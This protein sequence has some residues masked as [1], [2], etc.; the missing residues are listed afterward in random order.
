M[1]VLRRL[2]AVMAI[3]VNA[4]VAVGA[5]GAV[6]G[7]AGS[8]M[9]VEVD[10]VMFRSDVTRVYCRIL[11]RPHTSQRIDCASLVVND[12]E[13]NSTDIDGVDFERYFQWEDKG[14]I[15]LEIDFD[16]TRKAGKVQVKLL[17]IRGIISSPTVTLNSAGK[18]VR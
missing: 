11:G 8:N 14:V 5:A 18:A 4:S 2:L 17:T 15:P 6:P 9:A 7:A 3:A 1:S 16:P 12:T 13:L 10:S